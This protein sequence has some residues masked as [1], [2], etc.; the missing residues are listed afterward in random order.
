MAPNANILSFP[1]P[2]VSGRTG[3]SSAIISSA[4]TYTLLPTLT[5]NGIQHGKDAHWLTGCH[6][7]RH[8]VMDMIR[9][10]REPREMRRVIPPHDEPIVGIGPVIAVGDHHNLSSGGPLHIFGKLE[11]AA[12]S[13]RESGAKIAVYQC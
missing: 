12:I 8:T 5:S 4:P 3:L 9:E 11:L 10:A 13:Q 1:C 6:L 7:T 2:S